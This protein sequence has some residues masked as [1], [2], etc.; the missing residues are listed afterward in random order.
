[1][2]PSAP[3]HRGRQEP[4]PRCGDRYRS[5]ASIDMEGWRSGLGRHSVETTD[6]RACALHGRHNNAICGIVLTSYISSNCP[7]QDHSDFS[8]GKPE[9]TTILH[10]IKR[11]M[12]DVFPS[13]E[14]AGPLSIG[15]LPSG[16]G[17]PS[18]I[19]NV[20]GN[21]LKSNLKIAIWRIAL[22]VAFGFIGEDK[23][24]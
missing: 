10:G 4:W 11:L 23:S 3:A 8:I 7:F 20:D 24:L 17:R 14:F 13:P 2:V 16:M 22:G 5:W 15:E 9:T 21:F 6:R 19:V 18:L 1:M 12:L